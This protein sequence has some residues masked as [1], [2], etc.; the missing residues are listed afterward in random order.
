M[1]IRSKLAL[2]GAWILLSLVLLIAFWIRIQGVNTLP[3]EQFTGTDPYLYYWQAQIISEN[4]Q[5]PARDMHRWLP[6]GRDLGQTL[7]LYSYVLAYTHKAVSVCLPNVSLYHVTVYAPTVCFV[8]GL[9]VLCMFLLRSF[10]ILFSGIVGVLLATLPGTIDRSAAGFS[11]RDSWCWFLGVL[12]ITTYLTSL[13]TRCP[14]KRLLFTIVSGVTMFLG[15]ISWEGF[16]VFL[17]IILCVELWKCLTSK[18]EEGLGY[19]LVWTLT[20]VPTLFLASPA[21]RIGEGFATHLSAFMLGPP[22]ALLTLRVLRHLLLTKTRLAVHRTHGR[23]LAI[24]LTFASLA[25]ALCYVLSQIDTFAST[26]VPLS[27]NKLMQTIGEL[28]NPDYSYWKFRYGSVFIIGSIGAFVASIRLWKKLGLVLTV[29]LALFTLTTFFQSALDPVWGES[30]GN[31]F[32]GIACAACAIGILVVASQRT[33]PPQ[34]ELPF[35]AAVAWFLL[36]VA[37]SRDALRYD[38]F[39]G[40]PVAFFTADLIQYLSQTFSKKLRH[41]V[42]TTDKFRKDVQH[43]PL[44]IGFAFSLLALLMFWQPMGAH[45]K[46]SIYAAAAMRAPLPGNTRTLQAFRWMQAELPQNAIVAAST[47]YGGQLNVLGGVKTITDPDH[48]IQNWIYLY[49]LH[50][51]CTHEGREA[52]EFLRTHGATHLML[53]EKDFRNS[54]VH[55]MLGNYDAPA[56]RFK[57]RQ[58]QVT[59]KSVG[60]PQRLAG[61]RQTPFAAIT[62]E[63]ANPASIRARLKTGKIVNLPYVV[64]RKT[65]RESY[66]IDTEEEYPYGGLALYFDEHTQLQ[67]AYYIP[68]AGWKSLACRL[69]IHGQMQDVFTRVYPTDTSDLAPVKVWEIHY[70][71]DIKPHPKYLATEPEE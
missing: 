14:R 7:N 67:K 45:T 21:Y 53:T 11:D 60:G 46:R 29:T 62:Y 28:E 58:L 18:I 39:I 13:Q 54:G 32:F 52:L 69:Y 42:Y 31:I 34:N 56:A 5:L 23:I 41:S 57:P 4:G 30:F 63:A 40:F 36:W 20:F 15:G 22:L 27:Q 10:G 25:I 3:D 66:L 55:A 65:Q 1:P 16:G 38:F 64:F 48:F 49:S 70:P 6:Y 43:I 8:I 2:V 9:A 71:P 37:L 59:A 24:G 12:A 50:V 47:G 19:Y 26:T 51:F 68:S 44:K 17:C 33:D 35:V 61:L